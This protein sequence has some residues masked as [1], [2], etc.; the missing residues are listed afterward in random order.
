MYAG[1]PLLANLDISD[2]GYIDNPDFDDDDD[3]RIFD[4]DLYPVMSRIAKLTPLQTLSVHLWD[5]EVSA[6]ALRQMLQQLPALTC[7]HLDA[8]TFFRDGGAR[9]GTV[10]A[11]LSLRKLKTLTLT[12]PGTL[13]LHAPALD[14]LTV[15]DMPLSDVT[16]LLRPLSQ[17][18]SLSAT[19]SQG[20]VPESAWTDLAQQLDKQ[21]T[22]LQSLAVDCAWNCLREPTPM[23]LLARNC[24]KLQSLTFRAHSADAERERC[25]SC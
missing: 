6:P 2:S 19:I 3:D 4:D 5:L 14:K 25:T 16:Q 21:G 22:T 23:S 18:T 20:D 11:S 15:Q 9:T 8:S 1:L 12:W 13:S 10:A 17:L 24:S 7:L